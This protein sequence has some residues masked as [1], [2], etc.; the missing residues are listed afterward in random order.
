[1]SSGHRAILGN[2]VRTTLLDRIEELERGLLSAGAVPVD[3]RERT[4]RWLQTTAEAM[5]EA[6]GR[7][8]PAMAE[9]RSMTAGTEA[10]RVRRASLAQSR[11]VAWLCATARGAG[12]LE[13]R[14]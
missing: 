4:Q 12:L 1:M 5:A 9:A 10:A 6:I 8:A 7:P 13:R 2:R 3:V 11:D 14:A